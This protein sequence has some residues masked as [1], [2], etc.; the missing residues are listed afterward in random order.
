[1]LDSINQGMF[2]ARGGTPRRRKSDDPNP[3]AGGSPRKK[4]TKR[5]K[6]KNQGSLF[7]TEDF[8]SSPDKV[9]YLI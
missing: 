1:M 4:L 3:W 7:V 9:P 6:K 5:Q 8:F 2:S